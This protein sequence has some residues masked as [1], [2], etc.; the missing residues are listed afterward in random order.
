[1]MEFLHMGG[2]AGYIWSSYGIVM[3]VLL[4]NLFF[5]WRRHQTVLRRLKQLHSSGNN[6]S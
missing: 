1:M 2:Y 6:E 4:L 3:V 5:S